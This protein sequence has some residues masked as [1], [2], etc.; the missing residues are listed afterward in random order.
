MDCVYLKRSWGSEVWNVSILVAIG[1]CEDGCQKIIGEAEG[2]KEDKDSWHS[3]FVWLRERGLNDMQ[4]I[5]GDKK[6]G[7]LETIL[8]VF[9]AAAISGVPFTFT[10]TSSLLHYRTG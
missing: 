8:V 2:I 6:L 5:I 3:F 4:L 7:M 1:V 9:P 10:S